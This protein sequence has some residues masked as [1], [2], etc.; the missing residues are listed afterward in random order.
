MRLSDITPTVCDRC[1]G[2]LQRR[3]SAPTPTASRANCTNPFENFTLEHVR[4]ERGQKVK[5]NSLKELRE[6]EKRYNFV[7]A[8][9]SQDGTPDAPQ[10]ESW[11]GD[12]AHGYKWKS[13][14]GRELRHLP[15]EQAP[16]SLGR[17]ADPSQTLK[18]RPNAT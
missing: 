1:G 7:L 13:E 4:D 5:V 10:H 14:G 6:A 2:E 12:I 8:G 16:I 17:A 3:Y 9:M 18:D 15:S 11:A